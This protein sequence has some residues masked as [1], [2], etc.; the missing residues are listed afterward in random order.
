MCLWKVLGVMGHGSWA[1]AEAKKSGVLP[2]QTMGINQCV[3]IIDN[4]YLGQDEGNYLTKVTC[5]AP[6]LIGLDGHSSPKGLARR[7][8]DMGT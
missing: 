8:K 7:P 4:D 3:V 2:G 5:P 6:Q 1:E